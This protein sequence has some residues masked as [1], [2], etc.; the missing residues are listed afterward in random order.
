M[1][2][3]VT[4]RGAGGHSRQWAEPCW[5]LPLPPCSSP[6]LPLP[7]IVP[8]ILFLQ[9]HSSFPTSIYFSIRS[10][11]LSSISLHPSIHQS[12]HLHAPQTEASNTSDI[13]Q[14]CNCGSPSQALLF[15]QHIHS[16]NTKRSQ[17]VTKICLHMGRREKVRGESI[18]RVEGRL[19]YRPSVWLTDEL[20]P[21]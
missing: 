3:P 13:Q 18:K 17:K 4:L 20:K 14:M 16:R 2:Q 1:L 11:L 15:L 9:K 21:T 19:I 8:T 10:C 12:I 5:K 7:F 6:T